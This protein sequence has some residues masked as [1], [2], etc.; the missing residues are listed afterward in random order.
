M[1][2]ESER[3]REKEGAKEG[4]RAG[5]GEKESALRLYNT[6]ILPVFSY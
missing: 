4:E 3:G 5:E 1:Q 6:K 2:K